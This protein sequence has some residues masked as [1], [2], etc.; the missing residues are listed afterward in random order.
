MNAFVIV[1]IIF[2]LYGI[3]DSAKSKAKRTKF[4]KDNTSNIDKQYEIACNIIEHIAELYREEASK[5]TIPE[6]FDEYFKMEIH[7]ECDGILKNR[8]VDINTALENIKPTEKSLSKSNNLEI[9]WLYYTALACGFSI[10]NNFMSKIYKMKIWE[11]LPNK[12]DDTVINNWQTKYKNAPKDKDMLNNLLNLSIECKKK[13]LF[14]DDMFATE[15]RNLFRSIS[16]FLQY[17]IGM[18]SQSRSRLDNRFVG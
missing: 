8:W 4:I 2:I 11:N 13:I 1:L 16:D 12:I 15:S 14:A 18:F 10:K 7:L 6:Y 5:L 17:V 9:S 3:C